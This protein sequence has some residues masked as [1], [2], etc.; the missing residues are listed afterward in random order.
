MVRFSWF[1]THI[2]SKQKVQ[3]SFETML[4]MLQGR[5]QNPCLDP[6]PWEAK[7]ANYDLHDE[8]GH[9]T[10]VPFIEHCRKLEEVITYHCVENNSEVLQIGQLR[11]SKSLGFDLDKEG[12]ISVENNEEDCA[13]EGFSY[14]GSRDHCVAELSPPAFDKKDPRVT[15]LN[16][17][18][19]ISITESLQMG[20]DQSTDES[21]FSVSDSPDLGK[22]G[23][24]KHDA[25]IYFGSAGDSGSSTP[26]TPVLARSSSMLDFRTI[27][28]TSRGCAP[29]H[30]SF[31]DLHLLDVK[32][33][34][35]LIHHG[36][37]QGQGGDPGM[38]TS[39]E[40]R[41]KTFASDESGYYD[42]GSSSKDSIVPV[43]EENVQESSSHHW[44]Q[45][46]GKDF[47]SERVEEW[48]IDLQN[49]G[50]VEETNETPAPDTRLWKGSGMLDGVDSAKLEAKNKINPGMEAAKRCIS[51]LTPTASTAQLANHGLAII[52][53]LSA[54]V[55]LKVLNLS[56]NSIVRITAG[57]LPR[58]LHMLNLSKNK[59]STI[60]CLRELTRLRLLNLS[61][62]KIVRIG[63]GLAS[64]SSLKEL[65][66]AGNKISEVEGLHRLLKLTILDL[67]FNKISTSKGLGQLAAN[68]NSLQAISLEGNPAQTNV[69]DEQLKKDLLGLL[70]HLAYYNRQ[71]A[72]RSSKDTTADRSV[73]LLGMSSHQLDRNTR[74]DQRPSRRGSHGAGVA[75]AKQK[76]QLADPP[77]LSRGR[78]GLL[79]PP[80]GTKTAHHQLSLALG[81][82]FRV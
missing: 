43:I 20:S 14:D 63:H 81:S 61:Y 47:K 35:I 3:P 79:P 36:S 74:S 26:P 4:K 58:G 48:V 41:R 17:E 67:R 31:E 37:A 76:A 12:G 9:V 70:P 8:R 65:Y 32:M 54:F 13:G 21:I 44:D 72:V 51:F 77:R 56:G 1:N 5:S 52:P 46:L 55:S 78:R 27:S 57:A 16:Q 28:P 60:E 34:G 75:A 42:C 53:F 25:P 30:R 6:S 33:K 10:T 59:I 2:H 23:L 15:P 69:G 82:N 68:Y 66:L 38:Y 50:A 80:S 45:F 11:R 24:E 7:D 71:P 62:N 49:C 22:L 29:D 19:E 73:R 64:C 40:Y 18:Q 39:D